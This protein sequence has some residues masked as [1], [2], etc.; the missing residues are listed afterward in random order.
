MEPDR[1]VGGARSA[2]PCESLKS[3]A[4]VHWSF[5]SRSG[6]CVAP[7]T[8][9]QG[10]QQKFFI[11]FKELRIGSCHSE[12]DPS[13]SESSCYRPNFQTLVI[14]DCFLK[15]ILIISV[16]GKMKP[17]SKWQLL[18][19]NQG[20]KRL[21]GHYRVPQFWGT[22]QRLFSQGQDSLRLWNLDK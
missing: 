3:N 22:F 18:E 4:G 9:L 19:M 20:D 12:I 5:H 14:S 17:G 21:N 13:L 8:P 10:L 16:S 7:S 2:P 1:A 11:L 6:I 15:K